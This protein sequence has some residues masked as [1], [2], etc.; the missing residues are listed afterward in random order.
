MCLILTLG[1]SHLWAQAYRVLY[2]FPANTADGYWPATGVV[3]DSN[4]MYGTTI[5]GG[6]GGKG[7]LYRMNMD[8]SGYVAIKNF[9]NSD[10]A[11]PEAALLLS[12][13]TLFGST[14]GGGSDGNGAIFRLN[15]DGS[16]YTILKTFPAMTPANSGTNT[17]GAQPRGDLV[18]DGNTLYGTTFYGGTGGSGTIFRIDTNGSN[19]TVL[20][21]F[22]AQSNL[23]NSDG[24]NP[25]AGLVLNGDTLYGC[26][27]YGGVSSNGVI[28]KIQTNG[29]GFT[30]LKY[31][32][33]FTNSPGVVLGT[34][35][36]GANP[37]AGLA[38]NGGT[39]YGL[40]VNGGVYSNGTIY[41]LTTNG[42]GFRVLRNYSGQDGAQPD[43]RLLIDG[44]LLYGATYGGISNNGVV[45]QTDTNGSNYSVL[46]Y[47][48]SATGYYSYSALVVYSNQLVGT[49]YVGGAFN[50]GAIFAL[51]V[52]PQIL[53]DANF[54]VRS[55]AF[56]FDMFGLS[57][58][59]A[60]IEA[61]TNLHNPLWLPV[62]TNTLDGAP[63][64]FYD[65]GWKKIPYQF[66]RLEGF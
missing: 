36:D 55:N 8:G 11:Y 13:G 37:R 28:F 7:T 44:N 63:D 58:Q 51:T 59:V 18:T 24:A 5:I 43:N 66:Y 41:K 38:L 53:R 52:A 12:G 35:F 46:Q 50:G 14:A 45:F 49:T 29:S 61:C 20:K 40:T 56:G 2:S 62:G 19:F 15:T 3:L 26:A 10:G 57:N 33:G 47:L 1:P 25:I 31:F 23:T 39:L 32:S 9:T 17:D 21:S 27:V 65:P 22:S 54:G 48:N 60:V 6:S 34:N 42:T 64:Y 4:A 30:V 16:G